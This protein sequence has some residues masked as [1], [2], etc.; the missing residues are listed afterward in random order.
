MNRIV[1]Q[2]AI[3]AVA[4]YAAVG[5]GWI[6]GLQAEDTSLG[7][8]VALGLIMG[9]LNSVLR[10]LLKILSFPLILVTLGLF[11]IVINTGLFWITGLVGQ[12][13]GIGYTVSSFWPALLGGVIVGFVNWAL[14]MFF[15]DELK[16]RRKKRSRD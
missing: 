3:N 4:M 5:L 9:I 13:F 11:L 16:P 6:Q 1:I 14:S 7:A 8:I 2:L 15:K 12:W 10:P